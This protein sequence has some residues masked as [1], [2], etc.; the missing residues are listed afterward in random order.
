M[1][2]AF[3]SLSLLPSRLQWALVPNVQ[4]F[5]SPL[6][7]AVRTRELP[8]ARWQ[9]SLVYNALLGTDLPIMEAWLAELMGPAG[10]FT[11][12]PMHRPSPRGTISGTPL[13]NG[14][15]QGGSSLIIDG[16]GATTTLLKGDFFAVNSELK[17]TIADATSDGS[18]NATLSFKPPL[19]S[20]PADNA[21]LTL[22]QP[23][24]TFMLAALPT[25]DVRAPIWGALVIDGVEQFA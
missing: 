10:R 1:P 16:A 14:A 23:T 9:F 7:G 19:R 12:W 13:V 8:G 11:L 25:L 21:P 18:G 5:R 15:G 17:Q 4:A 6:S 20:A 22:L 3:P 24:T 2:I